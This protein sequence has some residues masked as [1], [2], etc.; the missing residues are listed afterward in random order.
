M[1]RSLL[2]APPVLEASYWALALVVVVLLILLIRKW[3]RHETWGVV[4]EFRPAYFVQALAQSSIYLYVSFYYEGIGQ[5][6]PLIIIQLIF[7]HLVYFLVTLNQEGRIRLNFSMFPIVLSINLFIW[8]YPTYFAWHLVLVAAAIL[9]KTYLVREVNGKVSHIFNPSALVMSATA[10]VVIAFGLSH[11]L[12]SVYLIHNYP[13]APN[14]LLLIFAVGAVSQWLGRTQFVAIGAFLAIILVMSA[15]DFSIGGKFHRAWLS[16]SVFIGVTLLITDPATSPRN[17]W[18]QMLFGLAYGFSVMPLLML[19]TYTGHWGLYDKILI[20][21][22]LNYLAPYLD[23]WSGYPADEKGFSRT[24]VLA[25]YTVIFLA[26]YPTVV[27]RDGVSSY[28]D[29]VIGRTVED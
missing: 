15:L 12:R 5:H 20:V 21:P 18:A 17:Q 6:A 29:S 8:F 2:F 1:N 25:V 10:V 26:L 14:V 11:V 27:R 13:E 24:Q 19:L 7:A 9:A 23:R 28:W 4:Y 16:P 22:L 3:R